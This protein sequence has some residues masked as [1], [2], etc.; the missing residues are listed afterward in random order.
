M[1]RFCLPQALQ[2]YMSQAQNYAASA[3]Y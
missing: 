3:V 2:P 1:Q